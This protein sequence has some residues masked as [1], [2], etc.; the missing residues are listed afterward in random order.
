MP[1]KTLTTPTT[2]QDNRIDLEL[3]KR[4]RGP[5]R[6]RLLQG[7][8]VPSLMK[9][10][11]EGS[12]Y[13]PLTPGQQRPLIVG[14]LPHASCNPSVR[15]CGYCTFPHEP[16]VRS[17]VSQ[18]VQAVIAEIEHSPVQGR[19]VEALYFGGGT[20][21]LTPPDD[22][23]ALARALNRHFSFEQAEV[24]LEGAPAFFTSQ[25][26]ALLDILESHFD[27]S[28][29]RLSMG[30][31]SFDPRRITDMGR[32]S[33]GNP[34]QVARA[35]KAAQS[36]NMTTSADLLINLPG[37]TL[38]EMKQ[39][40]QRASDLGFSQIC[41]Y[42]LVL[43]RGL[44]TPWAA[45]RSKLGQLPDNELA[46]SNWLEVREMAL[47]L[48][49]R[50]KTLTNFEREGHY[51][52]EE[53]SYQAERFDGIGFG[54][55]A[56]SIF[57]DEETQMAVKW[58]NESDSSAYRQA[59]ATQGKAHAQVFVYGATDMRLLHLTRG[60]AR[61]R[62]SLQ[63]YSNRFGSELTRDFGPEIEALE[64]RGLVELNAQELALTP[65]GM[66]FSDSVTG[67]LASRRVR[68]LR[69]GLDTPIEKPIIRMG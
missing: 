3:Q 27:Q 65:R 55:E 62:L 69:S 59:I 29:L 1:I 28:A 8:P 10:Y 60:L 37:Q 24:T 19:R 41:L 13:V 22:F 58:M 39:D 21:N 49:Y 15:G 2:T 25:K 23:R 64:K 48:G 47:G 31:Q 16:F 18:T 46:Y 57:S 52:Y 42:H 4:M 51:R 11:P 9:S 35:V 33:I 66:F 45:D 61:L 12:S 36:R 67:L 20:A 14:V 68:E 6:H 50:Q 40:L 56:I 30:V 43:F 32:E 44:G 26:G 17:Q 53:F 34:A 54:P 63:L 38:A 7:Y 5:Q